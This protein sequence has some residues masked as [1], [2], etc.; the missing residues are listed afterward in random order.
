MGLFTAVS[1][2]VSA[3]SSIYSGRKKRKSARKAYALQQ[4]AYNQKI[5]SAED[6]YTLD[7]I[8]S[9]ATLAA[10]R[11][12]AAAYKSEA[13]Y[14]EKDAIIRSNEILDRAEF[15]RRDNDRFIG[16]QKSAFIKSGFDLAGTP[17]LILQDSQEQSLKEIKSIIDSASATYEM[18]S[19][20][21]NNLRGQGRARLL[22]AKAQSNFQLLQ[23]SMKRD[24]AI[25]SARLG[26]S[27]AKMDRDSQ[28]TSSFSDF[29]SGITSGYQAYNAFTSW[30]KQNAT[31][32]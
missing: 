17:V 18:G 20:K 22:M 10:G 21:A 4:R 28:L 1:F 16:N 14:V 29:A 31:N 13:A 9:M 24:N 15:V 25:Q 7:K 11:I 26:L 5:N 2:G 3:V 6:A 8:S 12:D 30:R 23:G 27:G 32:P 19:L